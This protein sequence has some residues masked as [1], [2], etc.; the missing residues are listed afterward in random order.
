LYDQG[1]ER[2]FW[3]NC[4]AYR[5]RFLACCWE[6]VESAKKNAMALL[7]RLVRDN[8]REHEGP[9]RSTLS[10]ESDDWA[11]ETRRQWNTP[12]EYAEARAARKNLGLV[13]CEAER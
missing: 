3:D 9:F 5:Q 6:A 8:L 7:Q 4:P 13:G 10:N 1:L 2:R 12:P 11:T